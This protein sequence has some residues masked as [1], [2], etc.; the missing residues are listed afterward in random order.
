MSLCVSSSFSFP[1]FF[2]FFPFLLLILLSFDAVAN[3][4][5]NH[6]MNV[7]VYMC[8]SGSDQGEVV[9][10]MLAHPPLPSFQKSGSTTPPLTRQCVLL[11]LCTSTSTTT[12][13]RL[14]MRHKDERK[15]PLASSYHLLHLSYFSL[16]SLVS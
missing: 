1:H 10:E 3:G 4:L 8:E 12:V 14:M 9:R 6:M 11:L 13:V 7:H 16:L 15:S 2:F 5:M